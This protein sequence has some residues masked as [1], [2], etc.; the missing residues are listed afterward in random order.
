MER[1]EGSN[2]LHFS[3]YVDE[4]IYL[5]I[6]NIWNYLKLTLKKE[7]EISIISMVIMEREDFN[8]FEK[9]EKNVQIKLIKYYIMEQALN[10]F[11]VY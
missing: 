7:K 10:Q 3:K 8:I 5:N 1:I 6:M 11:H 9:K 4:V 2:I